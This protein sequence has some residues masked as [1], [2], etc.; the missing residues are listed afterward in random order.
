MAGVQGFIAEVDA[1]L[2]AVRDLFGTPTPTTTNP[3]TPT[4]PPG[5]RTWTGPTAHTATTN[6]APYT[7]TQRHT[8]ATLWN[9][10][11]QVVASQNFVS[12]DPV[13]YCDTA[14]ITK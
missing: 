3:P 8:L 11:C 14:L 6:L 7:H 4:S 1:A 13:A 10:I 5:L 12:E 9:R 2:T